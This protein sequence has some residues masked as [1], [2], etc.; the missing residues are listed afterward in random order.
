MASY[1]VMRKLDRH[2]EALT[3]RFGGEIPTHIIAAPI[4]VVLCLVTALAAGLSAATDITSIQNQKFAGI[5]KWRQAATSA[6]A[7]TNREVTGDTCSPRFREQLRAIAFWPDG[8]NEFLFIPDRAVVCSIVVPEFSPPIDLGRPDISASKS[9]TDMWIERDLARLGLA[10]TRGMIFRQGRFAV[11]IPNLADGVL[12]PPWLK[13]ELV[14]RGADGAIVPVS[15]ASNLYA[16][17]TQSGKLSPEDASG[18]TSNVRC[19]EETDFCAAIEFDPR[20]WFVH[21]ISHTLVILVLLAFGAYVLTFATADRIREHFSF[22]ARVVRNLSADTIVVEYQPIYDMRE[23]RITGVEVLARYRDVDGTI[24]YPDKFIGIALEA[25]KT[26]ELTRLV[27]DKARSEL[28]KHW[29]SDEDLQVN[30]NVFPRDLASTALF[31]ICTEFA[32]EANPR[33]KLAIEIVEYEATDC[34][35]LGAKLAKFRAKGIKVLI[36]DFGTGYS[37]VENVGLLPVDG[38]KLDRSF[39]M[40]PADS[41]MGR[42]FIKVIELL[43]TTGKPLVIEGIEDIGKIGMLLERDLARYAQGYSI[44]RPMPIEAFIE[45]LKAPHL[46]PLDK[47]A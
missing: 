12:L 2:V 5:E 26:I 18:L 3:R 40:A 35:E 25:N 46:P 9:N 17:L 37:S 34:A 27:V 1:A 16:S 4:F 6:L 39:A 47:V 11:V 7:A 36:D 13:S 44:G 10:G 29:R 43:K 24:I 41:V 32:R 30:I 14:G 20:S 21:H 23:R 19:D 22:G 33:L 15:G 8:L 42:M 38:I 45:R 31:E 28:E